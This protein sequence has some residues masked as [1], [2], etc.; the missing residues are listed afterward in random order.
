MHADIISCER[1]PRLRSYCAEIARVKKRAHRDETLQHPRC[2]Y[3][4]L[5][6]HFARYT[7]EM[8]EMVCGVPPR[9][10][11]PVA[12]ALCA[13][14]GRERTSAFCYAVG[15]TQHSV[16]VPAMVARRRDI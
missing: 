2:V 11:L 9:L 1:C 16:G 5:K 7:P 12:E 3:Q 15:W 14:S 10:F 8:V 4:L 6:K 13:N